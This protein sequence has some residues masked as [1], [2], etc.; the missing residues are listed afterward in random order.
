MVKPNFGD[1]AYIPRT[2]D[3]YE[4]DNSAVLHASEQRDRTQ[5]VADDD[6]R[7]G[8]FTTTPD[9][10]RYP[11][12]IVRTTAYSDD[13][14]R[15]D[16]ALFDSYLATATHRQVMAVNAPGIDHF[17][18]DDTRQRG[19]LTPQQLETL[20]VRGSFQRVGATS[21]RALYDV[22]RMSG[23]DEPQF[24][25]SASSM[26]V[27]MAAGMIREAFDTNIDLAG[28]VL[29]EPVNHISRPVAK[30]GM[31]FAKA[32]AGAPGYVAMNPQPIIDDGESMGF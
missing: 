8:I 27:A 13:N 18:D 20:K 5:A 15:P 9:N 17:T 30:L 4:I 23:N 16:G 7:L 26:G 2:L 25:I 6:Q 10:L 24:I 29:A 22:A 21:M 12:I 28:V 3:G 14:G 31:Q 1:F 19:R 32:N 11:D